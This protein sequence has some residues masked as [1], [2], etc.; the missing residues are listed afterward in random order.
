VSPAETKGRGKSGSVTPF[1]PP[2]DKNGVVLPDNNREPDDVATAWIDLNAP[3]GVAIDMNGTF[4]EER[5]KDNVEANEE[6]Q[7][8]IDAS[9]PVDPN[10]DYIGDRVDANAIN[11]PASV[12]L[13]PPLDFR[14]PAVE[15]PPV[16]PEPE[17]EPEIVP[18]LETGLLRRYDEDEA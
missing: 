14:D 4:S 15:E 13:S 18:P 5:G 10:S 12:Y 7:A 3:L 1:H 8:L 6:A 2:T 17:P 11:T 16:E 9:E